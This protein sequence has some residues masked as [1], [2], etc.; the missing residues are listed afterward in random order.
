LKLSGAVVAFIC[1]LFTAQNSYATLKNDKITLKNNMIL[2]YNKLPPSVENLSDMF[3]KGMF[4][5]RIRTNMFA[6][7][8]KEANYSSGGNRMD[9]NVMGIGGS[10]I[11]KSATFK[12]IS[13]TIGLYTSQNPPFFREDEDDVKYVKAAKDTFSRYDVTTTGNYGMSVVAQAYLQY[14]FD[15]IS[16][17]AGRLLFESMLTKSNDTKMIPNTFDGITSTIKKL[18]K[19]TIKLAW[20]EKQKLRDHT[21]SHDVIA[22]GGTTQ[23]QSWSQNDDASVNRNLT[24]KRIGKNNKLF[25]FELTN[26]YIK[27]LKTTLNYTTVPSVL[28]DIAFEAHYSIPLSKTIKIIPG[29]RYMQQFNNLN[30]N[31]NVANLL[32]KHD[33]YKDSAKKSLDTNLIA[34]RIDIKSD[35]FLVRFGYSQVADKADIVAPWRGFPTGGFTRALGQYNWFANTKTYML[36][37]DYDFKKHHILSGFSVSAR[38]AIEDFNDKKAGVIADTN[39]LHVDMRQ[40]IS[41]NLQAKIRF[42]LLNMDK[43]TK[44][45][46]NNLKPD[47]SYS[48]YRFELNYFF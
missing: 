32:T 46:N 16:I 36:R 19:T 18:D 1:L 2:Q 31:Y 48:E 25:V 4:Y 38:Y 14:D 21:T 27:N 22:F 37:A 12:N 26:N 3:L 39:I 42:A 5:G 6:W 40:N 23:P 20:L 10:F 7:R 29:I 35:A 15:D 34:C 9:D 28:S 45:I 44:D 41:K 24:V 33:G 11:Y 43:N 47:L 8:W 13:S 17:K 30:A